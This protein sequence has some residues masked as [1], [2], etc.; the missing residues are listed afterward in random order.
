MK[1]WRVK[2]FP[3][4]FTLPHF[5]LVSS[6]QTCQDRALFGTDIHLGFI[7]I[8]GASAGVDSGGREN[9]VRRTVPRL[10]IRFDTH[11]RWPP[12]T[13]GFISTIL[14]KNE[15]L[16]TFQSLP[17][18][19]ALPFDCP[20]ILC[21]TNYAQNGGLLL[22]YPIENSTALESLWHNFWLKF[23]IFSNFLT[24]YPLESFLMCSFEYLSF[25]K[26]LLMPCYLHSLDHILALYWEIRK[27]CC[28]SNLLIFFHAKIKE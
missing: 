17:N 4:L 28:R 18:F 1:W 23:A 8:E 9:E 12:V 14:R 10:L 27:V 7:C 20:L 25:L 13:K 16:W 26:R 21:V 11:P 15:G 2:L 3:R 19:R 24:K 6:A 22:G 5:F